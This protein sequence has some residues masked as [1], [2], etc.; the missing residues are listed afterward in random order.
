VQVN[1]VQQVTSN[2]P[3][4]VTVVVTSSFPL[5]N[6]YGVFPTADPS[7]VLSEGSL[8]DL[9]RKDKSAEYV[10]DQVNALCVDIVFKPENE[11][12]LSLDA[13][14]PAVQE[15]TLVPDMTRNQPSPMQLQTTWDVTPQQAD[16]AES[17]QTISAEVLFVGRTS[18]GFQNPP[19]SGPFRL[20]QDDQNTQT[21]LLKVVN[22]DLQRQAQM[23]EFL[24][25]GISTALGPLLVAFITWVSGLGPWAVKRVKRKMLVSKRTPSSLPSAH[26]QRQQALASRPT[27]WIAGVIVGLI[28]VGNGLLIT[29]GDPPTIRNLVEGLVTTLA[30]A[31]ICIVATTALRKRGEV[32]HSLPAE[33]PT[34]SSGSLAQNDMS[35]CGR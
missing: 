12:V 7:H 18:C 13:S 1:T 23:A 32:I 16:V 4:K 19:L 35:E 24:R 20:L 28:L 14:T 27:I 31:S 21:A 3:F 22:P 2:Q 34:Q 6:L 17:A 8:P 9:L 11:T 5:S 33:T 15:L 10:N 26:R 25:T 29:L 30:G